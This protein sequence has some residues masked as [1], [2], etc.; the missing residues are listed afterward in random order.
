MKFGTKIGWILVA[1]SIVLSVWV[2]SGVGSSAGDLG[3]GYTADDTGTILTGF[4][5]AARQAAGLSTTVIN[6]IPGSVTKIA[7]STFAGNSSITSVVIP[8]TVK[9]L[10]AGAF[11][12][13]DSLN[14]VTFGGVATIPSQT[15]NEC[16]QLQTVSLS[17][18]VT[19]IKSNAFYGC[20]S[21]G[22]ISIP[23]SV[24]TVDPSAF[25]ECSA[26]NSIN[27]DSDSGNL[28]SYD[29]CLYNLS[30]TILNRCPEG[31]GQLNL[32]SSCT[33][34]LAGA[35]KNCNSMSSVTIPATVTS[36]GEQSNWYPDVIYGYT[37]S[38]AEKYAQNHGI[39]F[40]A[41]D[42]GDSGNTDNGNT[43]NS[44][45]DNGNTDNGNTGTDSGSTNSGS[46]STSTATSTNDTY[47]TVSFN[48]NGGTGSAPQQ[49]VKAHAHALKPSN[50]TKAG[51]TFMGWDYGSSAGDL[52]NFETYTVDF[53]V[54]L[55]AV[56]KN[57]NGVIDKGTTT[58][59]TGGSSG[60]GGHVKDSTPTT[61]DGDIDPR[62]FLSLSFLLVGV[63][64]ILYSKR[65]KTQMIAERRKR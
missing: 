14:S 64:A 34:I 6:D 41:L 47:Y 2:L 33:Q 5:S 19:E 52:W 22:S 30:G 37:G 54:T 32:S 27:V 25:D 21:L 29:G 16:T 9:E 24:V 49:K 57:A 44:N 65:Q 13:C 46:T 45:T 8:D 51:C 35:L 42:A 40:E 56:W 38:E 23:K 48:L 15:F 11:S 39:Q 62:Y 63:A 18:S 26:L 1:F 7:A 53:N 17:N 20:S 60:N 4:D 58:T 43:D 50:P 28:S 36:I 55:T 12:E 3:S 31:K 61:A 59:K 10:D